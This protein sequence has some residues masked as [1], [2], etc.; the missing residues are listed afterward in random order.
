M[1]TAKRL[2][3]ADSMKREM[4]SPITESSSQAAVLRRISPDSSWAIASRLSVSRAR[5]SDSKR[6]SR[7]PSLR[8]LA[9]RRSPASCIRLTHALILVSGVLSS[10]D[11]SIMKSLLIRSTSRSSLNA[12]ASSS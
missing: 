5:C 10:C 12:T 2:R 1:S 3:S 8:A 7:M 4:V 6:S 9:G 11:A